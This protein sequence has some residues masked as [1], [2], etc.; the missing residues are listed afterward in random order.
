MHLTSQ[1]AQAA[2]KAGEQKVQELNEPS[3]LSIVDA[4]GNLIAFLRTDAAAFGL[5]DLATNKAYTAAALKVSTADLYSD[6]QPGGEVFGI[7]GAA[8]RPFVVFG[9]GIPVRWQ[10]D[11]IAAVG[12][13]GGP[14][15]A[16]VAIATAMVD[17]ILGSLSR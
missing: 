7:Q 3:C 8:T 5:G 16:D 6:A 15:E 4:G 12:V 1:I 17:S 11:V 10:G 2:I 9:G 14:V 13:S